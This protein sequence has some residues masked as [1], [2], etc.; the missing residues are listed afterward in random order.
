MIDYVL[1]R[2]DRKTVAI[3]VRNGKVE[4]RAPL[5]YP[6]ADI[7]RFVASKEKWV[8]DKLRLYSERAPLVFE[9]ETVEAYRKAARAHITARVAFFA[10]LMGV[11]PLSI[12]INSARTRWG[13]CSAKK[14]LNFSWRLMLGDDDVIDYVV[15]HELA[16]IVEM[17]H[18]VRFWAVVESVL[19]DYKV[20][21]K[22]L[23]EL[24]KRLA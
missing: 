13:S 19:P 21:R 16:H 7:D 1:N 12:S 9:K 24:A 23:K 8:M 18:S 4:V 2:S 14:R 5:K 22:R 15:V 17:N 20:R 6:Q 11:T 3:Y 10:K